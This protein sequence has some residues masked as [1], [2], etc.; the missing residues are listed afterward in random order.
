MTRRGAAVALLA[1]AFFLCAEI[2]DRI[3]AVVGK[4]V[5]TE[6]EL[7]RAYSSDDLGLMR[8]HPLTGATPEA[9]TRDEYLEYMIERLVVEQEVKRQGIRVDALEV[10]RAIDRK[11]ESL[12]LTEDEFFRALAMQGMSMDEY[13]EQVKDQLITFRLVS[14]EV[15]GEIEV[16]EEEIRTYYLQ[17]PEQFVE[18]DK[19]YL[20]HIFIP[21]PADGGVLAEQRV[22][23][24]LETV[25]I[26][27]KQGASFEEMAKQWSKS[28]T[29]SSGGKLGW[30]TL[31]ELLPEFRE[32]ARSLQPGQMSPVFIHGQGA[33]LILLEQR[34]KGS[35]IPMEEVRDKIRDIIFQQETMQRYG[36]WLER[37]KARTHIENRLKMTASST[38]PV[39]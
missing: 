30:F 27:I 1:A 3:V 23:N 17:H 22:V 18:E 10:E 2:V 4:E 20:R 19:L 21:I 31:D 15:R 16:T 5:I 32:Q 8:P 25:K 12:G 34:K 6:R 7:D 28:P 35:R 26:D 11:R 24:Q 38:I 39:P 29:A 9:L 33:H 13:R 37:L 14:Q 36:L